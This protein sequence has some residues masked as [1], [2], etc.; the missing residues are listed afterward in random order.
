MGSLAI[1]KGFI[2]IAFGVS[3]ALH[4]GFILSNILSDGAG[5]FSGYLLIYCF[6]FLQVPA[7]TALLIISIRSF[8]AYRKVWPIFKAEYLFFLGNIGSWILFTLS[9]LVCHKCTI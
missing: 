9:F 2:R 1:T 6:A 5:A 7:V 8:V 3:I 4:I